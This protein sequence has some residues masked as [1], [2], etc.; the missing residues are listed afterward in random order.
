MGRSFKMS[1][2][3]FWTNLWEEISLVLKDKVIHTETDMKTEKK[4][5]E[6][7][8]PE[9]PPSGGYAA[10]PSGDCEYDEAM[11]KWREKVNEVILKSI[12]KGYNLKSSEIKKTQVVRNFAIIEVER[13]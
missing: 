4:K 9:P 13:S 10:C 6:V 12:P 1:N 3:K 7:E 11:D 2:P 5:M 8:L